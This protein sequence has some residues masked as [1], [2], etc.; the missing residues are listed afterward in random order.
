MKFSIVLFA[1]GGILDA[2]IFAPKGLLVCVIQTE[3]VYSAQTGHMIYLANN[4]HLTGAS[5]EITYIFLTG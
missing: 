1:S 4:M 5:M 2:L 3:L